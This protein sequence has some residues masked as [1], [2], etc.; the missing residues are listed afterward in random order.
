MEG[1]DDSRRARAASQLLGERRERSPV[2]IVGHLLAVQAQDLRSAK[3]ALW[4]RGS[5]FG[6]SD[7]DAALADGSLVVSWL[8]RGT[9]HL[10]RAEDWP[11]LHALTAPRQR[12]TSA[13]RLRQLGVASEEAE[14]AV[15]V[16]AD[17]LADG[18]Q[19]REQLA[20]VLDRE[21]L[22]T[23]G[24]AT[25]HL[26]LRASIE[27]V[28][29]GCGERVY[30]R[31]PERGDV[32]LEAAHAELARRYVIAHAPATEPDLA[33]WSGL[34]LHP[35][36]ET[37]PAAPDAIPPRLLPAFD[38]YLLGWK[39]RSFAVP[40][41]LAREVHPGGGILRAVTTDDGLV[42]GTWSL[43]DPPDPDITRFFA[44]S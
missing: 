9:L 44:G 3:L 18:P 11:W 22:A 7:V 35:L 12:A 36:P 10:V 40:A 30:R 21:G 14:R 37:E 41:A 5:G 20:R 43:A 28:L 1:S 38:P 34:P 23:A 6:A 13:R 32:D 8:L 19:S 26:L 31:A 2:E 16:I 27:G 29:V 4:A 33:A 25:P 39:D 15:A 17:A 42:T 24:Q